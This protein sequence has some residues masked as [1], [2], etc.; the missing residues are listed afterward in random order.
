MQAVDAKKPAQLLQTLLVMNMEVVVRNCQI[1]DYPI[2]REYDQFMGDRRLDMER[3]ELL[4]SDYGQQQAVGYL[5][6]TSNE[7]FNKPLI[8][9]VNV[10]EEF[11]GL[12][13]GAKLIGHA[14]NEAK[15]HQ[16][17]LTTEPKNTGMQKLALRLGFEEA[18]VVKGLNFTGEDELIFRW[19][20]HQ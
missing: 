4:V 7:F 19:S 12:G 20:R 10:S 14:L 13:I 6:L 2:I 18:G 1:S 11:R 8:S 5:K 15:W 9:L 3:G 17:Y 16:V